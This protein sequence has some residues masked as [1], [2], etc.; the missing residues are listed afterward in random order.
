MYSAIKSVPGKYFLIFFFFS[1]Q[2]VN[3]QK[4]DKVF[5]SN[6]DIL[7]GIIKDLRLAMLRFDLDGPGIIDIKWEKV[8]AVRSDKLFEIGLQSGALIVSKLDSA[9]FSTHAVE[10]SAI[11]EMYPIRKKFVRRFSGNVSTG[12]NYTKSSDV[13]EFNFSSVITYRIPKLELSLTTT[14]FITDRSDDSSLTKEQD[15]RFNAIF[16]FG[17]L[18]LIG[19]GIEW[20]QNTELGVKNRFS[21][22]AFM[23]KVLLVNNHNRFVSYAG[24]SLNREQSITSES[25]TTN[26]ELPFGITYKRFFYSTPKQSIDAVINAYPS[27]SD[28]GRVRMEFSLKTS[29]EIFKDF[30][31][32][33]TFYDKFD[34]RPPEGASSK[35]DFGVAFTVSYKFNN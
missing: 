28:W 12:I 18:Y 26:L 16:Y 10:L 5:L 1:I 14:S 15:F 29:I 2:I 19:G 23:G 17:K 30:N 9:F 34:N 32:G 35:N 20:Q 3:G 7:T 22:K 8:V 31:T 24:L 27:L 4:T 33:I 25:Y 11:I 13:F 21:L 6:G